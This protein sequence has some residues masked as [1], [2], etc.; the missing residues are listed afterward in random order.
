M[1]K[2][3]GVFLAG[4]F[5]LGMT[6]TAWARVVDRIVA[7]VNDDIITL[8]ELR[9]ETESFRRDIMS[10][11]PAAQQEQALKEAEE[12]VL[13]SLIESML[14]YQKAIELEYDGHMEENITSYI[15][16]I[17]RDNNFRD[18]EEFENALAQQG[19]SLRTFRETIS[20]HII[21]SAL[22]NDFINQ[23]INLL[24][25]EIERYYQ[26]HLADFTTPEEVTLS[27]IVLD[28]ANG[29]S[30]AENLA[31]DIINRARQGESFATLAGRYSK[32]AT[33]GRGGE[34]GTYV[35]DK[36][37]DETRRALVGVEE[38]DVSEPQRSARDIVIYRVDARKPAIVRPMDEVRDEISELLY[39]QRRSPEY[40]RFMTQL[41]EEAFIQIFPEM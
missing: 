9:R 17:M 6:C 25:P 18:T 29:I 33:A 1:K 2:R 21:S 3:T 5:V 4:I 15:Q 39:M 20:R 34:I 41:R 14:I 13:N 16:Q 8:S 35:V 38:G 31:V 22:V 11:V 7:K 12:Q 23:R 10:R 37:N 36:L 27:E 40:E 19:D 30:E 26:N 32:G 28:T 24:T